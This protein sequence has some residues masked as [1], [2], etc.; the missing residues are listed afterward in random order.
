VLLLTLTA[1]AV[2]S[3]QA[4][5]RLTK[6]LLD[7]QISSIHIEADLCYRIVLETIDSNEVSVEAQ[8][9]GEYQKD[10]VVQFR[11]EG[12]TLFI[13]PEF[14]PQFS[15][16]NDKLGAHKVVSVSMVVRL[17]EYQNVQLTAA[18]C[19]VTA[20]GAYRDLRIVFN[21]GSCVLEHL[22]ENTTVQTGSAAIRVAL[23][24]GVVE[25][26]SRYGRVFLE[27][28]PK[29]DHHLRLTST[30]GDISVRRGL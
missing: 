4:Q 24:K 7:P 14:S 17:P 13:E 2:L 16:P 25:A 30:R 20:T 29:G 8:M 3:A 15:L 28:V 27:P 6:T 12:N 18:T 19:E 11:E 22:A 26:T 21:D 5:K 10:L 23:E 1:F 9:E